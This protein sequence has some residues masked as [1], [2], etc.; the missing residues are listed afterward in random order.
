MK[1]YSCSRCHNTLYFE[2]SVCLYCGSPVGFDSIALDFITLQSGDFHRFF[3]IQKPA[4]AY[5]F[6]ANAAHGTCNW[7]ITLSQNA[8]FC[9][10]CALNKT[11]P[12][13]SVPGNLTKW[14]RIEV[15]KHRLVYSLLRLR[16]PFSEVKTDLNK[17]IAFEFMADFSPNKRVMTG[18]KYGNISLNI[19]EADE[20]ERIR[21][22]LDLGESYRTL[23]GHLRHESGHYFWEQLISNGSFIDQ[24][25]DLFGD[26]RLDYETAL[27]AYYQNGLVPNWQ[28]N[29][30]SPYATAHPLE[31]WA[32]TWSHYMLLM[33]TLET[34]YSFHMS[35]QPEGSDDKQD[36]LIPISSDPYA[37]SVFQEIF[38]SWLR[39][40]FA[41]NS[42][43]RSM[44]YDDFYPFV[45]SP[46]VVLKL[47]FIHEVCKNY[48]G[49]QT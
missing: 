4:S 22:K 24:F 32:E 36:H 17:P 30:I 28:N 8:K 1:I 13:L 41:I 18:Y 12:D 16:L 7:L 27:K 26:E 15:A 5:T 29:F 45:V 20:A 2:N 40:T 34:S 39:L 10:A 44:G 48:Q 42:L 33:D 31:D 14:K 49:D 19:N 6:C 46:A 43:N 47:G 38:D 9:L 21:H 11:I 37:V 35:T 25:R 23:L 3:D